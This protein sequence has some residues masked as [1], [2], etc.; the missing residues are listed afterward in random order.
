MNRTVETEARRIADEIVALVERT[1][2]PVTFYRVEREVSGFGAS[3]PPYRDFYSQRD[4]EL[5]VWWANMSEAGVEAFKNVL[6]GNR[7]AV[8]MVNALPY[9]LEGGALREEDWQPVVLLPASAANVSTKNGLFRVPEELLAPEQML[10]S[11]K[12]LKP[13]QVRGTAQLISP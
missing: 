2:G 3:E 8:A 12:V 5:V 10:P 7:I 9:I 6:L 1:D 4:G 11:W 13:G